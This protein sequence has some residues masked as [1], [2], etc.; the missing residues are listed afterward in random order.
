MRFRLTFPLIMYIPLEGVNTTETLNIELI[1]NASRLREQN[2]I[3]K[4]LLVFLRNRI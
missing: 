4:I 1:V 2:I 3:A